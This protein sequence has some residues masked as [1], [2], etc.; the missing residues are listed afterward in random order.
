MGKL[1]FHTLASLDGYVND[2]GGGFDWATPSAEVHRFINELERPIGTYL[3]G[4]RLY[5]AMQ[6]WQ[7]VPDDDSRGAESRE[8]AT[9]W[10][11]ADKFVF[12]AT[13]ATVTTPR[14]RLVRSSRP[15][16]LRELK[17]A[18]AGDLEVG[19]AT[20]AASALRWGLVDEIRLHV[21]PV[22]VG[23]GTRAL[24]EGFRTPLGLLDERRHADGTVF[25][26]YQVR[27]ERFPEERGAQ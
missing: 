27:R 10:R 6:G 5:E 8:Y 14:T 16:V 15:E 2:E 9:I 17:E 25:L 12:S 3:Y 20:L 26:R 4:R 11:A 1:I 22:T 21:V 18:A 23:G 19:G 13:L 24:P 7:E